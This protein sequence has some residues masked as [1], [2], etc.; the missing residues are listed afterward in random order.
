MWIETRL[1]WLFIF[2]LLFSSLMSAIMFVRIFEKALFT[3]VAD[4]SAAKKGD[5]PL[6]MLAPLLI[7][8][9]SLLVVGIM[10]KDIILQ[11]IYFAIPVELI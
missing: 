1:H 6:S 8:A 4:E 3:K 10:T 7:G 5:A 11:F 2:A 9:A